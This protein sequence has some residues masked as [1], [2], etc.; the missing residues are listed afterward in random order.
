[1][2]SYWKALWLLFSLPLGA[3][4]SALA[5]AGLQNRAIVSPLQVSC[6]A[7]TG[8]LKEPFTASIG[9]WLGERGTGTQW[10]PSLDTQKMEMSYLGAA[11]VSLIAM[12]GWGDEGREEKMGCH[13][14]CFKGVVL[15]LRLQW[16]C[17]VFIFWG[18]F[19]H[20]F[21]PPQSAP[22]PDPGSCFCPALTLPHEARKECASLYSVTPPFFDVCFLTFMSN[23]FHKKKRYGE[24]EGDGEGWGNGK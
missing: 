14:L 15:S 5:A 4:L 23:S 19:A 21:C 1:M 18:F 13:P 11:L 3:S 20:L 16:K 10:L 2:A 22:I 7:K 17:S 12:S 9:S 8:P 6:T 24:R